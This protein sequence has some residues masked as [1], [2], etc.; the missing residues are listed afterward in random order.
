[1]KTAFIFPG[2]GSQEPRMGERFYRQWDLSASRLERLSDALSIDLVSLCLNSNVD[3]LRSTENTQPAVFGVGVSVFEGLQRRLDLD[4]DYVAGHSL[5]HFTALSCADSIPPEKG[6]QI[7]RERGEIMADVAAASDPGK[8]VAIL[9]VDPADVT[10]ACEGFEAV[11][12][13]GFNG[14]RQTVV[15]GRKDSVKRVRSRIEDSHRARFVELDVGAPFHSPLM[16]DA[17]DAFRQYLEK[18]SFKDP[19]IPVVSDVSGDLYTAAEVPESELVEQITAP[20]DWVGVVET[21][22]DEG[23]QRYIEFPPTGEI[24]ELVRRT[25]PEAKVVSL[26]NPEV[27]TEEFV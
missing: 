3:R 15:S 18:C 21:L 9:F 11:S 20:V 25:H 12:V 14:P 19:S 27:I 26:N 6:V 10:D 22:R 2:Q 23:V 16:A 13:A 1:M 17:R 7:V 4:P 5:G 24:G 8:M